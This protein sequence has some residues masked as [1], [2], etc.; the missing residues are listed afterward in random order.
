MNKIRTIS[1]YILLDIP[2]FWTLNFGY[3]KEKP[4]LEFTSFTVWCID[5]KFIE[6]WGI[7]QLE[8][9]E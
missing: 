8:L 7:V 9:E 4:L 1:A 2:T 3:D 6:V 5:W